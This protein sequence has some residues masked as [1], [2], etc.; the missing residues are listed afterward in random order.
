MDMREMAAE[1]VRRNE[2]TG[3]VVTALFI[4]FLILGFILTIMEHRAKM[5]AIR[6]QQRDMIEWQGVQIARGETQTMYGK[7]FYRLH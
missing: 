2:I 4:A 5:R 7:T 1:I 6:E 3:M